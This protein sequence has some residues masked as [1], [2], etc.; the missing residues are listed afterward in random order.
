MDPEE[1]SHSTTAKSLISSFYSNE[2]AFFIFMGILIG[3]LA[4]FANFAFVESYRFLY[5][6]VVLPYWGS[7]FVIISLLSGGL[8]LVLLSFIFPAEV[9]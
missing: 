3:I 6:K 5:S 7:S 4:G 1:Q 9:L 8:L 2:Y